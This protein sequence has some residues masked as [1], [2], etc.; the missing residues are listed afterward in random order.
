MTVLQTG[1][2]DGVTAGTG[3]STGHARDGERDRSIPE[4]SRT[5]SNGELSRDK[6]GVRPGGPGS[7]QHAST[8]PNGATNQFGNNPNISRMGTSRSEDGHSSNRLHESSPMPPLPTS[9]TSSQSTG[10]ICAACGSIVTGQFVRALGVVFHK[11]CFTCNA[12]N[13][14][15]HSLIDR[16]LTIP[17]YLLQDCHSQ[18]AQ[19]FFP[20]DGPDGRQYP[21]CEACPFWRL[22]T[23]PLILISS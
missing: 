17:F 3:S 15:L 11:A 19:K 10:T 12:S 8:V 2:D 18:V 20:A 13:L 4:R 9:S 23:V 16:L 1:D 5:L 7:L 14:H 6:H 21:L 22:I